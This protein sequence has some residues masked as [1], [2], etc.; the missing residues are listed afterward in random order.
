MPPLHVFPRN[1]DVLIGGQ[2]GSE[3]KGNIC[4]RIAGK[5][6]ILV[7]TGGPNAGHCIRTET[8]EKL[9]F[10]HLPSGAYHNPGARLVLGPGA[11]IHIPTLLEEIKKTRTDPSRISIDPQ[12]TIITDGDREHEALSVVKAIGSTGQGVGEATI[13]KLMRRLNSATLAG[14]RAYDELKDMIAP[15][16]PILTS[17]PQARI[18]VE[19]TQGTLLSLHH[20]HWP[21]V[22][23]RDTTASGMLS[24]A[25][26]PP[27]RVRRVIMVSRSYPIRVQS[28]EGGTSGPLP[29]EISWN[30]VAA[31][32]GIGETGIPRFTAEGLTESERTTTT[33]RLR[34]VGEFDELDFARAIS[35]N[36][37][38]DLALT[39]GDYLTP[40]ALRALH[41]RMEEMS[42]VP[43][44]FVS[45]GPHSQ[46]VGWKN[47]AS[48]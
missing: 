5:Y 21:Y 10:H 28:P 43:V 13:A 7:R 39:F 12:A 33:K 18:L 27:T 29:K 47:E 34:R 40:N 46:D 22:T 37:P 24:E 16:T 30:V 20:G 31:R 42:D 23:S 6:D 4:S 26:L 36:G 3:G 32:S 38:T 17:D 1:V 25:G 9:V 19:G 41:A 35:L 2:Y 44:S 11:V 48:W 8:G 14:H 45:M 15:T